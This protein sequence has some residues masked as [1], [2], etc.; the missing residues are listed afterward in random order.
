MGGGWGGLVVLPSLQRLSADFNRLRQR[1][2][3]SS[4]SQVSGRSSLRGEFVD[5]HE[6][7]SEG[8]M[9]SLSTHPP[10]LYAFTPR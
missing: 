1:K 9:I 10:T 4:S 3:R 8:I 5:D 2:K 7:E 6:V